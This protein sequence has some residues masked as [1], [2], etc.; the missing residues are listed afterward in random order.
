[1]RVED[2]VV[3]G[4]LYDRTPKLSESGRTFQLMKKPCFLASG[5]GGR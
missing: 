5:H 2:Y 1:M 4:N 3:Y